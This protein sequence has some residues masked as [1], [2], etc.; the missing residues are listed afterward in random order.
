MTV[1]RDQV[2]AAL[3]RYLERFPDES[4][5]LQPLLEALD[6]G[7]DVTARTEFGGGHV[8]CGAAVLDRDDR[9]LLIRHRA[10][11]RWL[12]PGGHLEPGDTGLVEAARRELAEE[13]GIPARDA[14]LV[15][16]GGDD[17]PLDIDLHRVPANAGRN[18]P[19][20][21]H[22]DFRYA[23]RVRAP[24]IRP[25]AEE[26]DGYTWRAPAD[27]PTARLAAKLAPAVTPAPHA[28]A[29]LPR[30]GRCRPST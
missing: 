18:E 28:Q 1:T 13:T 11:R 19:A 10:L 26:V 29:S 27:A 21:W 7:A 3:G 24:R 6:A 14:V 8:T 15:P 25:Q 30:K 9:L 17:V 23:C 16:A 20:H 2:Q 22:A 12:M 5:Q 4:G